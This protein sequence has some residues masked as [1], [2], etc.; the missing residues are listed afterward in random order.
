MWQNACGRLLE[1]PCARPNVMQ[2]CD[3]ESVDACPHDL[4]VT[5]YLFVTYFISHSQGNKQAFIKPWLDPDTGY[6][7]DGW[8]VS[9]AAPRGPRTE[10]PK[11]G[12]GHR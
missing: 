12:A 7:V 8:W 9:M 3:A 6:T 2:R 11:N 4:H 5:K 10:I 1:A